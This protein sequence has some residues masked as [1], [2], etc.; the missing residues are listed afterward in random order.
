MSPQREEKNIPF[1]IAIVGP[2]AV[3]KSDFAVA[4]A[5]QLGKRGVGAEIISAD[6]RQVY[7][8][9]T[10]GSGKIT[11]REMKGVPHHLLDVA[12]PRQVFSV[13]DFTKQAVAK[14]DEIIARGNVPIICGGTGLYVDTLLSGAVLPEVAPNPALRKK[15]ESQ[16]AEELFNILSKLDKDRASTIDAKN[17]VRLVRAI[18][19]ATA[20]GKVPKVTGKPLFPTLYIGLDADDTQL[21]SNIHKRLLKRMKAGMIEEVET[22][23]LPRSKGGYGLSWKRLEALGLEY[24]FC[25]QF[26]QNKKRDATAKSEMLQ[27][28]EL[29]IWQYAKRQRTWW[30]RNKEIIWVC[31]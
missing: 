19:I 24:K 5:R 1:V 16:S 29:A 2:T 18:E 10:I 12:D 8:G 22:L 13:S 20:L 25:A 3:G 11:K 15:L 14:I 30:K 23:H 27:N 21:Q 6:S 4:L 9:L 7:R 31:K 28:L 26:L 17:P